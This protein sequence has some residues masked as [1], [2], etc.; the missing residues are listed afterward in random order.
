M[1]ILSNRRNKMVLVTTDVL[2]AISEEETLGLFRI[3]ATST[4]SSTI[5]PFVTDV[6][7][8]KTK[9]TRK[10]FYSRMSKLTKAGLIMRKNGKYKLTTF[11]KIIYHLVQ[12]KIKNAI[13][14]YWKLKAIDSIEASN[15][16]PAEEHKKFIDSLL[17]NQEIKAILVPDED[18][19]NNNNKLADQPLLNKE[20]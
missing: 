14:N 11:G 13:N 2:K 5:N 20:Q 7:I 16:L 17:D 15:H 4:T 8:S 12:I 6:L 9:L 18:N 3:V 10:Q 1:K 19:D